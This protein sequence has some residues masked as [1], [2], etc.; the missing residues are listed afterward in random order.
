VID[1]CDCATLYYWRAL[2]Q[3]IRSRSWKEIPE[4][5][6]EGLRLFLIERYY[7][8][9]AH[10]NIVV[11]PADQRAFQRICPGAADLRVVLNGV[12]SSGKARGG[13]KIKDRLIFSGRMDFPPNYEGALWFI[14]HVLPVLRKRNPSLHLVLAGAHPALQLKSRESDFIRITG[15]VPD[16]C[17]ELARASLYVAPLISG[18]GFKNKVFEALA[19]GTAV[20]GTPFAAEFLPVELN[21]V[22]RVARSA[23]E[24][25]DTV[26]KALEHPDLLEQEVA[27]A[28]RFLELNCSWQARTRDLL[29]LVDP[30][31]ASEGAPRAVELS[32]R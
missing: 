25:A 31:E 8:K 14:D 7:P 30:P 5:L 23:E 22:V 2:V 15:F 29:A 9:L 13:A 10:A 27:E 1:W 19:A 28:Q 16:M 26:L 3:S 20:V 12:D 11:S 21:Q 24:F 4:R 18:T 17:E 6:G 32:S